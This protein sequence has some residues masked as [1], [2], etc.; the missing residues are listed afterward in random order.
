MKEFDNRFFEADAGASAGAEEGAQVGE[1]VNEQPEEQPI[2]AELG[3]LS[4]ETARA[5]MAEAG[6]ESTDDK[7]TKEEE[8][9]ND[10]D[11]NADA[12]SDNKQYV[13]DGVSN[14]R[15]PY[16]RFKEEL[17]RK[18]EL[19]EQNKQLQAQ[20]EQFKAMQVQPTNQPP[21]QPTQNVPPQVQQTNQPRFNKET[22]AKIDEIV[23]QQAMQ[24]SGLSQDDIDDME[25]MDDD[26]PRKQSWKAANDYAR[27]NTYAQIQQIQ[28]QRVMQAQR[29]LQQH[30]ALVNDYNEFAKKEMQEADYQG[31]MQYATGEYFEKNTSAAEQPAIA[32]AYARIERQVASP[33]DIALI[34]RFYSEAKAAYRAAHPTAKPKQDP[35]HV[36]QK[37]QQAQS[38]PRSEQVNGS[39]DVGGNVT[40][41]TLAQML[42]DRDWD[43]IPEKYQKM[44]LSGQITE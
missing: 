10:G 26:D 19:E 28:A 38:F 7:G 11:Q 9:G 6:G 29:F 2:P 32:Q 5:I 33:G 37:I 18:K 21:A 12:D 27:M 17:D 43:E 40:V 23:K 4:E 41:A 42:Q 15:I 35:N 34:K 30:D 14:Q 36:K 44:L 8:Q 3:G 16:K 20:I 39:A 24:M 22:I 13:T 25:F 31:I 1:Q